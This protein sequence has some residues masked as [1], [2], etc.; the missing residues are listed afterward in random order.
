MAEKSRLAEVLGLKENEEYTVKDG[1]NIV[2][3]IH[4]G[5][6]Q[7]KDALGCWKY[8]CSENSLTVLIN[9]P[10]LIIHKP[11]FSDEEMTMLRWLHEHGRLQRFYKTIDGH[12]SATSNGIYGLA[13]NI[14][15][16]LLKPGE[17]IDLDELFKEGEDG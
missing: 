3:R 6:R 5:E 9:N 14:A 11:R 7:Y 15:N 8:V 4:N 2:Y 17:T 1:D 16:Y 12:V 10:S 13:G